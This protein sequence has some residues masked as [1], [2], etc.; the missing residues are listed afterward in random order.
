MSRRDTLRIAAYVLLFAVF[1]AV[2]TFLNYPRE[3]L[4][5][6]VNWWL[7]RN[8]EGLAVSRA[9]LTLPA[10]MKLEGL[11]LSVAGDPVDLGR[12]VVTP[13][14]LALL[15]GKK[16]VDV[17]LEGGWAQGRFDLLSSPAGWRVRVR[18]ARV[19][20]SRIPSRL[21]PLPV[22]LTGSV[23]ATLTLVSEDAA[24]GI[25]EGQ[26]SVS[27]GPMTAGGPLLETFGVAPLGFTRLF[28]VAAVEDNVLTLGENGLEG[29]LTAAARG[30]VRITPS[31]PLA[32]RVDITVEASPG[33]GSRERL[34]PLLNLLGGR[35]GA[36]GRMILHVRGTLGRPSVTM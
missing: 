24:A 34:A 36:D 18:S 4:T 31:D 20:L 28:A 9:D 12:A 27:S 23:E 11:E 15:S 2:F 6:S 33:P 7:S 8:V 3:R 25:T 35:R 19:D 30:V 29:D 32:S 1:T 16:G 26:M 5:N 14:W 22:E 21:L 17:R 13:R 10:A